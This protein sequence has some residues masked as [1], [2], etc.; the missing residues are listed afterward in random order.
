LGGKYQELKVGDKWYKCSLKHSDPEFDIAL[1]QVDG[2]KLKSIQLNADKDMDKLTIV[3]YPKCKLV[4]TEATFIAKNG[5][6][7]HYKAE[8]CQEG[9]SGGAAIKDGKCVGMVV[10]NAGVIKTTGV[11]RVIG[12]A[13]LLPTRRIIQFI[14]EQKEQP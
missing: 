9:S 6:L 11:E 13:V 10:A 3:M 12:T 4:N 2:I 7:Y 14:N 8:G 1:L 5:I